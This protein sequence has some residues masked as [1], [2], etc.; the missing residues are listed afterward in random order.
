MTLGMCIKKYGSINNVWYIDVKGVDQNGEI[1][2]LSGN[3]LNQSQCGY[4]GF[5]NYIE[6]MNIIT[7][8]EKLSNI[9]LEDLIACSEP[10][11]TTFTPKMLYIG[12]APLDMDEDGD[13]WKVRRL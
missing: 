13:I 3:V 9:K 10:G 7:D 8:F 2:W 6:A 1:V 5:Y 11:V 12:Y 4:G